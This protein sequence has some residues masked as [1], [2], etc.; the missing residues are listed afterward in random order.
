[1][2]RTISLGQITLTKVRGYRWEVSVGQ[3]GPLDANGNMIDPKPHVVITEVYVVTDDGYTSVPEGQKRL[4]IPLTPT[5]Q[6]TL[7]KLF[8][9]FYLQ[10]AQREQ[11]DTEAVPDV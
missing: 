9:S 6:T 8:K 7:D 11:V 10:A 5:Q 4:P 1:M 3:V 2:P